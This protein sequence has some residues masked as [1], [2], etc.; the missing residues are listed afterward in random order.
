MSRLTKEEIAR[1]KSWLTQWHEPSEV[2]QY[3]EAVNRAAGRYLFIQAGLAFL[4]DAWA[5]ATLANIQEASAVRLVADEWPDFE[6]RLGENVEPFEVT[7]ADVPGRKRGQEYQ[8]AE[9]TVGPDG[10]SV[11]DDPVEEWILRAEAAPIALRLA[12][13]RKANKAYSGGVHLLIYLNISEFGIR[14]REIENCFQEATKAAKATF[15]TVWILWKATAYK[16]WDKGRP[17][18]VRLTKDP[19]SQP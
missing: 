18:N 1:H 8:E 16:V 12:A 15:D 2:L 13:Q 19:E 5:A 9:N 7:E 17:S 4:R 3:L 14:Q 6:L 10:I 11:E